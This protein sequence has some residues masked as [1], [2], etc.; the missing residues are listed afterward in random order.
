MTRQGKKNL[1]QGS[2]GYSWDIG[3]IHFVHLNNFIEYYVQWERKGTIYDICQGQGW[4]QLDLAS[5]RE[6]G[7]DIIIMVHQGLVEAQMHEY[8]FNQYNVSALFC[9]HLHPCDGCKAG[10]GIN[11]KGW[12]ETIGKVPVYNCGSS[13]RKDYLYVNFKYHDCDPHMD[14]W[15]MVEKDREYKLTDLL[16]S[17]KLKHPVAS[18]EVLQIK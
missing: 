14:I 12:H 6:K 16:D 8:L 4:L 5:A 10:K 7:K 11:G 15:T 13:Q 1:I 3:N 2:L 9:G 18:R 17:V